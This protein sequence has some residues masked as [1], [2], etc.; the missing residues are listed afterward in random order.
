MS[1]DDIIDI[2]VNN[3]ENENDDDDDDDDE[4]EV[5]PGQLKIS[6]IKAELKMRGVDFSDC[7]DRESLVTKLRTARSTGKA[8]PSILKEFNKSAGK[9]T[10]T[11]ETA[12]KAMEDIKNEDI[13][14]AVGNDGKLPGGM[15]P[16]MLQSLMKNPELMALLQDPKVQ[17]SMTIMMTQGQG[18]LEEKMKN[19]AEL[20][21]KVAKLNAIMGQSM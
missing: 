10:A 2:T 9:T 3:D 7:F 15:S 8:D 1:T 13:Q 12:A 20:R 5:E 19:D 17:E 6:E 21:E 18:A 11:S 4:E 14:A 16:D